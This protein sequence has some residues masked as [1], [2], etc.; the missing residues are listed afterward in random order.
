MKPHTTTILLPVLLVLFLGVA[1]ISCQ[2]KPGS[3]P[4]NPL[5]CAIREPHKCKSDA[6]CDGKMKCC[7]HQCERQCVPPEPEKPGS[8]P[9]N[10]LRCAI[11]EPHKCKSD[12]DCDGKMKCCDHQCERQCVPPEPG[13]V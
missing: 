3:C 8:C 5:R 7:D 4:F 1:A 11:R 13:S 12:A 2:E 9:F 6:D 10:P